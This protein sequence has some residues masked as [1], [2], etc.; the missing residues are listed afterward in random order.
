MKNAILALEEIGKRWQHPG[1]TQRIEPVENPIV[2][3]NL[4][5]FE[6]V[7]SSWSR[8]SRIMDLANDDN[9]KSNW[10]SHKST[11]Q[12][13]FEVVFDKPIDFN[14]ICIVEPIGK[15]SW[16]SNMTRIKSYELQ[17]WSEGAWKNIEIT[18]SPKDVKIHRFDTKKSNR[19]RLQVKKC[20]PEMALTEIMVYNEAEA[21]RA[22]WQ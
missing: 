7:N 12:P 21:A 14:M 8:D 10:R 16:Y 2:S 13:F 17:Y 3:S 22:I 11:Q 20:D 5:K 1:P 9:F 19:I 4:A 18:Y 15:A 6:R